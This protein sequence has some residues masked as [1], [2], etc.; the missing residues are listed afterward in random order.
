MS[1]YYGIGQ[2]VTGSGRSLFRDT[3]P[4]F[5]VIPP[6]VAVV[7]ATLWEDGTLLIAPLNK[8]NLYK[9]NLS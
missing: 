2:D 7:A 8:Y 6:T 1:N 9:P 4:A 5:H 3:F